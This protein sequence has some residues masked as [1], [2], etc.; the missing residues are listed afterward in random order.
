MCVYACIHARELQVICI[1]IMNNISKQK[2]PLLS[3]NLLHIICI[4]LDY[5]Q[6]EY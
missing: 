2:N 5:R 4:R 6:V 1:I 3:L